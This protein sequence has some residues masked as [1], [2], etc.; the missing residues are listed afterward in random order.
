[1]GRRGEGV[2]FNGSSKIFSDYLRLLRF[3]R[4][5]K[6]NKHKISGVCL[7][8]CIWNFIILTNT[9]CVCRG[10]GLDMKRTVFS[11]PHSL[12]NS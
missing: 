1:M 5:L 6:I 4:K 12:D 11:S 8:S 3:R 10:G 7:S 9:R 2:V